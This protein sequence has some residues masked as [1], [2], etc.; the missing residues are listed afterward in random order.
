MGYFLRTFCTSDELPPLQTVLVWAEAHGVSLET[1]SAADGRDW[2]QV[3]VSYSPDAAP[4]IIEANTG[5]LLTDEVAEF[6]DFL[7]DVDDSPEKQKVLDHLHRSKAV[8]AAQLLGDVPDDG[9]DP[10]GTFLAYFVENCG[11]M[12]QADGA[13]FYEGERLIVELE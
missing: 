5:D 11:V 12:I 6:V 7:E 1:T 10:V 8:V 3:E 4:F 2:E 9:F 13:G